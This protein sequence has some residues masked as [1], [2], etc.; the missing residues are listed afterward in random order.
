MRRD[1]ID[2][3]L[4][5]VTDATACG[6]RGVPAVVREAVAGG[7]SVVQLR[8]HEAT[9][10]ELCRAAEALRELLAGAGVPL[11]VD[12]RLDVALATGADGVHLGQSD[13]PVVAAREIAGP[14]LVI[15]WSVT[16]LR[17]AELAWALPEG[18]VDYLGVGPVYPTR[19]KSDAA[20]PLGV[21]GLAAVCA[22]SS[23]PCVAIGG[24]TARDAGA[25]A[26]AGASGMAVVSAICSAEDPRAAACELRARFTR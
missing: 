1:A 2:W 25:L 5:V 10:R 13:L 23:V 15:G 18:T 9:T 14:D 16:D 4:H 11:V 7:A 22:R 19:T 20:P 8:D 6:A 17:E 24:I 21:V 3:T 26:A 12:D